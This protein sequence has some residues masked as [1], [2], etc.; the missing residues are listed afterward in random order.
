MS[1]TWHTRS[2][3]QTA[4]ALHVDPSVGISAERAADTLATQGP[5]RL[6]EQRRRGLMAMLLGQFSDFMILVLVAAALVSGLLGEIIDSIAILVIILLNAVI[7]VVQEYRAERALEALKDLAVPNVTVRRDGHPVTIVSEDLVPGDILLLEAGNLVPAD[8]RLSETAALQLNEAALTGESTSVGKQVDALSDTGL[9]IGD[10]DNMAFRGTL[11]TYGRGEGVVVA[12]GMATEIGRIAQ[13]LERSERPLTPLQ[14][15]L[16]RF[17]RRLAM[18]VLLVCTVVFAFGLLR[19]VDPLLMFLTAVSLAVAAIPEALPAVITIALALGARKLVQSNALIRQL[20]AVETLGSVTVICSD[21]TGTLT[22]NRMQVEAFMLNG[23][24]H[25]RLDGRAGH[26]ADMLFGALALN[27]DTQFGGDHEMLGEPTE[28]ALLQAVID[29]GRDV[30][31]LRAA[32]P[33][34]AELPFDADRKMMTTVHRHHGDLRAFTKGAP[35]ALLPRC[36]AS[37]GADGEADTA[38]FAPDALLQDAENLAADGYRVLA[39]AYRDWQALPETLD[40]DALEADLV[41][42]GLVALMDPPRPEVLEAV[43]ACRGAGIRPVMVTGD[44]PVTALA[45]A[46]RLGIATASDRLLTGRQ[47]AAL[48][49]AELDARLAD[50][51]VF[52]RVAPEQKIRIVEGLQRQGEFVAMTGD[53][54]N[55]APALRRANIGVAM[56]EVGT[57]VA[58]EAAHMVLLDDNF[59]TIVA[60][61]R[62]GRRIFDNIRKF[63][64]YTMTSNSGE[65]WTLFLAPLLALPIPLLPIQILWINL[66]TD[67]LP[68]LALSFEPRE[69]GVMRRPPRPPNESIFAH[70]MG[71]HMLGIGL[72]IGALSIAAQAWSYHSGSGHWQTMVFNTLTFA[73]LFHVL[74]I[75]SERESLFTI[76]LFSNLPLLGAVT[77]TFVLQLMVTYLP[78]LQGV[79]NTQALSLGELV[80]CIAFAAVV[81]PV[82]EFEKWLIRRGKLYREITQGQ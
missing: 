68:G 25:A 6:V 12:T 46:E 76:G 14:Q 18:L 38:G 70:G 20:P 2:V 39:L 26:P 77:L 10:R 41:F 43:A 49:D 72:L 45:I 21:K 63:I 82:V 29:S 61:V 42:I 8:V 81:V 78:F 56:G 74:V 28:V 16:A 5:N 69:P 50:T 36:T 24:R 80:Q 54:V 4:E 59:A 30:E 22:Q 23:Q 57:D 31:V 40:S 55:D 58:R 60:A 19:G 1:S 73:Q 37:I 64:R 27:N 52:A 47:L 51:P 79:F 35:E 44:H 53:G 34:A 62:E 17:G 33:R 32:A 48:S 66:V 9:A 67:G 13:L 7:G 3:Q 15:R 71:W 75:R 11:V 65:I